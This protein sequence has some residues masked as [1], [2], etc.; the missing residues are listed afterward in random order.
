MILPYALRL[1]CVCL[2]SFFLVHLALSLLAWALA[3]WALRRAER[4][5]ASRSAEAGAS[6]LLGL[7]LSPAALAIG[8]VAAL[9][10]PSFLAFENERGAEAAGLPFVATAALGAA[11]WAIALGRSL[12]ALARS[13]R[14]VAKSAEGAPFLGLAGVWNPR[15]VVSPNVV[16]AL[17]SEQ[18]AAALRHE[19]GHRVSGDNWKRLALTLA[20]GPLPMVC[21]FRAVDRAWARFAEWAA[22]DWAVEQDA[23]CSLSLA[24]ALVRVARLGAA[25]KTSP[26]ISAFVPADEDISIRVERLLNGGGGRGRA[27]ALLARFSFGALAGA[28]FAIAVLVPGALNAVHQA[29]ERLMH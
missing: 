11:V 12:R 22:D 8:T 24:E 1:V 21:G 18:L 13:R 17:G 15:V 3:P 2:G 7:R 20:P 6:L 14:C 16:E 25:P 5:A 23:G 28:P 19:Q 10:L 4:V 27:A 9:C 29:L 26:L